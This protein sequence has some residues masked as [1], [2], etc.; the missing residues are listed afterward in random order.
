[1]GIKA[2]DVIVCPHCDFEDGD[3]HEYVDPTEMYAE[4]PL[5][6]SECGKPIHV[7]ME[8]TVKFTTETLEGEPYDEE[9]D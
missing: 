1:M 6:C 2:D 5:N 4:F 9:Y 7:I 3:W 8:T